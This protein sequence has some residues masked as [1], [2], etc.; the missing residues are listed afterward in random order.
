MKFKNSQHIFSKVLQIL[1]LL[2]LSLLYTQDVEPPSTPKNFYGLG[3]GGAVRLY[4]AKNSDR[5]LS[6]YVLYKGEVKWGWAN[7]LAIV[8]KTDTSYFD[9]N[10]VNNQTY[11][12]SISAIDSSGN[13]SARTNQIEVTPIPLI[14]IYSARYG[15]KNE[16]V[17]VI[18]NSEEHENYGY[19]LPVTYKIRFPAGSSPYNVLYKYQENS[20]YSSFDLK[21]ESAIFNN[22]TAARIDLKNSIVYTSIG[23]SSKSDSLFIKIVDVDGNAITPQF[24]GIAKYYDNRSS[25]VVASADDWHQF[26]NDAFV[27]TI[28]EFRNYNIPLTVG[29]ITDESTLYSAQPKMTPETWKSIQNQIDFGN[30]E[31]ASHSRNHLS[32]PYPDIWYEVNGSKE[33]IINN[34]TLP[35]MYTNSDKE[36]VYIWI[37]QEEAI[38]LQ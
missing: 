38:H 6:K 9:Y 31:I 23:F 7:Q 33:D 30:I 14:P 27:K 1:L 13:I 26:G 11:Y 25:V 32:L 19:A 36:Y 29:I 2:P 4:W 28:N 12:Y 21:E 35:S 10:V 5:D 8:N 17:I 16:E 34:L 15:N 22:I 37:A 3:D 20:N 24:D 18:L